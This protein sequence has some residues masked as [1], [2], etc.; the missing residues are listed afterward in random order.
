MSIINHVNYFRQIGIN[1]DDDIAGVTSIICN[2]NT[3]LCSIVV[4][5]MVG[6]CGSRLNAS[7]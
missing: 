6:V 1:N 5:S 3:V 4:L 7:A 2:N